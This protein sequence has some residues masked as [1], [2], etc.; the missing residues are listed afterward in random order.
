MNNGSVPTEL[1]DRADVI[2]MLATF[3]DRAPGEVS[4]QLGS[5]ELTWLVAQAEQRYA[6]ELDISD[7]LFATM[8]TVTGAVD[9][10]R[11]RI[12]AAGGHG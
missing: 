3:G 11:E 7:E 12:E 4:E 9:A 8:T 5:L 10:L 2:A 6:V 1:P